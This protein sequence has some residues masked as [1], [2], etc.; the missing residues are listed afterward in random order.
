MSGVWWACTFYTKKIKKATIKI[1]LKGTEA[2]TNLLFRELKSS[3]PTED[4]DKIDKARKYATWTAVG[5]IVAGIVLGFV[6]IVF[7]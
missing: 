7:F 1:L 4:I 2:N 3:F 5:G 6:I